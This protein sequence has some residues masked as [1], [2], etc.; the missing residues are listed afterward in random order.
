MPHPLHETVGNLLKDDKFPG[1]KVLKDAACGGYQQISLFC[2]GEKKKKARYCKVD[3]AILKDR[4]IRVIIE[5]DESNFRPL[6]LCGKFFI[7]ALSDCY[8]REKETA[9]MADDVLFI[10]VVNESKLEGDKKHKKTQMSNIKESIR[11]SLKSGYCKIKQYELFFGDNSE[12]K[13]ANKMM[14][15]IQKALEK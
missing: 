15:C 8:K 1:C 12:L 4:K 2:K 3:M 13:Q 10:Q 7:S 14:E 9:E 11:E 6:H 5:I